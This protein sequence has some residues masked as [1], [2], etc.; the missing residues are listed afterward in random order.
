MELVIG[1]PKRR[2]ISTASC[3]RPCSCRFRSRRGLGR[4]LSGTP[5]IY[6]SIGL[7]GESGLRSLHREYRA[8]AQDHDTDCK[9]RQRQ[10]NFRP[11]MEYCIPH[12]PMPLIPPP[13]DYQRPLRRAALAP[14]RTM[15]V[16]GTRNVSMLTGSTNLHKVLACDSKCESTLCLGVKES[17]TE[18]TEAHRK[19][20]VTRRRLTSD[21][22]LSLAIGELLF[23]I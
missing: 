12:R 3:G 14:H 8:R 18:V 17:A 9:K 6:G 4:A 7:R 22:H 19:Q 13:Q 1:K 11:V 21:V 5:G 10:H 20:T 2:A 16:S 23:V 15:R